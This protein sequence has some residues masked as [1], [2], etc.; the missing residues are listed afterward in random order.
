MVIVVVMA[1]AI[2]WDF[3]MLILRT[4]EK[5]SGDEYIKF[6]NSNT[7]YFSIW[8]VCGIIMIFCICAGGVYGFL[9]G[10]LICMVFMFSALDAIKIMSNTEE[11]EKSNKRTMAEDEDYNRNGFTN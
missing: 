1:I 3:I 5:L 11:I 6:D 10:I 9:F 2:L 7:S 4:G 8:I